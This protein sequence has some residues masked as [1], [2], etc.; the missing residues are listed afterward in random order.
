HAILYVV[1]VEAAFGVLVVLQ[2]LVVCLVGGAGSKWGPV[3]GAAVM[4]PISE[5]LDATIGDRVPCIQGVVYGAA[6]VL[7]ILFAPEGLYWRVRSLLRGRRPAP[8]SSALA[9]PAAALVTGGPA[10]IGGD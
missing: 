9:P 8:T 10:V 1:T 7:I 2:T 6:L 3:I 4:M 5:T